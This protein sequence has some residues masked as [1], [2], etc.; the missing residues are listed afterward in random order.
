MPQFHNAKPTE[1]PATRSKRTNETFVEGRQAKEL[2]LLMSSDGFVDR[3][4]NSLKRIP[5]P[6]K[7][8]DDDDYKSP[9]SRH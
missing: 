4:P 3:H 2:K 5:K 7:R 6:I 9:S 8:F 1:N